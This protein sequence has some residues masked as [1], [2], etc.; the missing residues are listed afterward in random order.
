MDGTA[1]LYC[2]GWFGLPS[3]KT[4]NGLVRLTERYLIVGVLDSRYAGRDA[5]EVLDGTPKGIPVFSGLESALERLPEKPDYIVLGLA[6]DGGMLPP[7]HR[8]PLKAALRK[9]INLDSG[10]H[11]FFADDPAFA[12]AARSGGASIRDIRKSP[13]RKDLHFWSGEI[14]KVT[15]MKVAILGTDSAIGKRTTCQLLR[16]GLLLDGIAAALVGTGQTAWFQ[17]VPHTMLLDA[18]VNDF[19]AGE[20]EHA[21]CRAFED[22]SPRVILIE[23]QGCL[24]HPAYPGGFEIIGACRPDFLIVQHAPARRYY[25]G[26]PGILLAGLDRELAIMRLLTPA[27]LLAIAVNHEN[28]TPEEARASA[29]RLQEQYGVPCVAP[30]LDSCAP[31]L[32]ALKSG[33]QTP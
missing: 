4:A 6:P 12:E 7:E 33:G 28:M 27:P 13:P 9:G 5:G 10:L 20:L 15:A 11:E 30:L 26:F 21:V 3:G 29:M 31:I 8:E 24:T 2:E 32:S 23:G 25:D 14:D 18:T 1:L 19:V 16:K 22:L 17:G